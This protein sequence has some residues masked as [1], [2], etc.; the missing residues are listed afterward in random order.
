MDGFEND[1]R[2]LKAKVDLDR[3]EL[4]AASLAVG[5]AAAGFRAHGVH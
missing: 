5:F 2:S 3:R 1:R 4:L